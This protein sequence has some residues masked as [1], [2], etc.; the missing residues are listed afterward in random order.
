ELAAA[1]VAPDAA[2]QISVAIHHCDDARPVG[3]HDLGD[4]IVAALHDVDVARLEAEAVEL[5]VADEGAPVVDDDGAVRLLEDAAV[6]VLDFTALAAQLV[7]VGEALPGRRARRESGAALERG[8]GLAR[9][10]VRLPPWL[11]GRSGPEQRRLALLLL[12][13]LLGLLPG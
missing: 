13:L 2:N 9:R 12:L 4:R 6:A 11:T 7:D 10:D 1:C 3:T 8:W 5:V